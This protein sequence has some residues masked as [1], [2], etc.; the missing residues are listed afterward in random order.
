[1]SQRNDDRNRNDDDTADQHKGKGAEKGDERRPYQ[2]H[3]GQTRNSPGA[4]R[5][6]QDEQPGQ[7]NNDNN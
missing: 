7:R 2:Q 4:R 6:E 5:T 1:M 3:K